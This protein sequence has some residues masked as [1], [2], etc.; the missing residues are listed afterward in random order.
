METKHTEETKEEAKAVEEPVSPTKEPT[1]RVGS[2]KKP[3]ETKQAEE[4]LDSEGLQVL[5]ERISKLEKDV[6]CLYEKVESAPMA[7]VAGAADVEELVSKINEIQSDM[8]KMNQTADRLID[9]RE[10]RE[11]HLNVSFITVECRLYE[12]LRD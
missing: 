10:N 9:D 3:A 7:G 6:S 5:K 2:P 8:E 1:N 12:L 11:M 4:E